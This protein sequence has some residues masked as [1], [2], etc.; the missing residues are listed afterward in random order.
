MSDVI[1]L[2]RRAGT[3]AGNG[4]RS[5]PPCTHECDQGRLCPQRLQRQAQMIPARQLPQA[6]PQSAPRIPRPTVRQPTRDGAPIGRDSIRRHYVLAWRWGM[7]CG[8]A[9]GVLS[10]GALV[11]AAL[12]LGLLAGGAP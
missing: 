9:A 7:I 6:A 8:A 1:P 4:R 11:I 12:K 2:T 3:A 5:C 10:G